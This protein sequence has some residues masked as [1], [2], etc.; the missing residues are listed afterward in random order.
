[1]NRAGFLKR[2][3]ASGETWDVIVVGGGATGLGVAVD[4]AARGFRTVLF[5]QHDF[6]KAT[7]SRSTKI[8][9]G[10][11]R[12]LEQG[13][14][15]LVFEA[16]HER[17]LMIRNAPHLAYPLTYVVPAFHWWDLP[18]YGIGLKLY[19]ALAGRSS[20]GASLV[21]DREKT[22]RHLP[23]VKSDRLVGGILYMD[24]QFDDAR[25]ALAL[26]MTLAD[27]GGI[28]LN[29]CPVES[30]LKTDGRVDGVM[31]RDLEGGESFEVRGRVVINAGGIFTDSVRRM[32]DRNAES[33]LSVSQGSHIVVDRSF[34]PSKTALL[35]PKTDDG[36]V[37]F[38]IPWY[39]RLIIGTTD[40][41]KKESLLEPRPLREE[42]DF[43]IGQTGRY[44]AQPI[45]HADI[46]SVFSGLRPLV[47]AEGTS[48][49][50]KL[51]R[52]HR[53]EVSPSKL[54]SISGGKWTTY[55]RMA[56]DT[57]DRAIREAGLERRPA[58]TKTLKLHGYMEVT[59]RSPNSV[60]GSDLAGIGRLEQEHPEWKEALHPRLPYRL[61]EAVWA[62]R[63]EMARTLEDVLSRRTRS[64]LLDA[65]ASMEAAPRVAG[66]MAAE[67][68]WD[69]D[70]KG[71][72]VGL[73]LELARNYL[74]PS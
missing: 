62:V 63:H 53:I 22:L 43:L 18:F 25:L 50:A 16:L 68:G 38:G 74:P 67:L 64:L 51:S 58:A 56:Q 19:D 73:Y 21:L 46:L 27:Q 6:A 20:L 32:D 23:T 65:R 54:V 10:G 49:T 47:R 12:Y 36:R 13:D 40:I 71:K 7:S 48:N 45:T 8:A 72:Q 4:A 52:S 1:M 28:P 11:V 41:P 60:Y 44:L 2:V 34:L 61:S 39:D 24:G 57:M 31:V 9:H 66:I 26:A 55:R 59:D 29:Y 3:R 5:E 35:I 14:V 37:L 30:L 33:I 17:G 69:G 15:G 42:I 70:R